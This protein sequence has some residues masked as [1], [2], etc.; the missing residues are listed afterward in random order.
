MTFFLN[1]LYSIWCTERLDYVYSHSNTPKKFISY[2]IL[3]TPLWLVWLLICG[4]QYD[5]GTDYFNYY[6]TF[7]N[8]DIS[9][10]DDIKGEWMFSLIVKT[11]RG[12]GMPPQGL[13]YVFYFV[14]FFFLCAILHSLKH[15][16]SFLYVLLYIS[17]STVFNNQLNGLRQYCAVYIIS[18]AAISFYD[19]RSYIRYILFVLLAAG[20]HASAYIM[21]PFVL[22]LGCKK[23]I[24]KWMSIGLIAI[25]TAFSLLG[26]SDLIMDSV[27]DYLPR[28]YSAYVGGEFD[29]SIEG[30]KR[31]TKFLFV[32]FYILA[33]LFCS[34][35][36][37]TPKDSFLFSIGIIAYPCRLFFLDNLILARIGYYFL[38]LSILPLY[39]YMKYLYMY[40][41][42]RMWCYCMAAVFLLF[43]FLKT[44]LFAEGEYDYHSIY[45]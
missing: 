30:F 15:R 8:V 2:F 18:Y 45:F 40:N 32:P 6:D 24:G 41:K 11:F 20:F 14:N 21:I 42:G 12:L 37:L 22:I 27:V 23:H 7:K 17:L 29:T 33:V 3:L 28:Y 16:T 44:V 10:Y 35:R 36:E 26:I 38:L 1:L 31:I 43:Y 9:L 25:A 34:K 13:F 39:V 4:G 19:N 5:V